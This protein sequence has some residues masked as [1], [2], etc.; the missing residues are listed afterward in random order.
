MRPRRRR[1]RGHGS[2]RAGFARALTMRVKEKI[3]VQRYWY[4]HHL[5]LSPAL[6]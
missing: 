4:F 2:R 5:M 3:T 6:F 1:T